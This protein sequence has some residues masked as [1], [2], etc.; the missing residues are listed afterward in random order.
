M[1]LNHN[2]RSAPISSLADPLRVSTRPATATLGPV[3][4]PRC[5]RGS[6][7]RGICKAPGCYTCSGVG[8]RTSNNGAAGAISG[9]DARCLTVRLS[10]GASM[11]E[12]PRARSPSDRP[13][14]LASPERVGAVAAEDAARYARAR[15]EERRR[16]PSRGPPGMAAVPQPGS[17]AWG[18]SA[19]PRSARQL[20]D[21]Y[22]RATA[23]GPRRTEWCDRLGAR[24]L[25]LSVAAVA[26]AALEP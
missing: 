16:F 3:P 9:V 6:S 13:T 5:V 18:L 23:P 1:D 25:R 15:K 11:S 24:V 8:N 12:P 21:T 26:R 14:S 17:D 22:R 7:S 2:V 19:H 4:R 20:R 10:S